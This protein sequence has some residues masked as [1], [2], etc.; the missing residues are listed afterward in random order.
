VALLAFGYFAHDV[1]PAA[2][3][4]IARSVAVLS[5]PYPSDPCN[6]DATCQTIQNDAIVGASP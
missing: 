6:G 1:S 5:H 3:R 4:N 2:A